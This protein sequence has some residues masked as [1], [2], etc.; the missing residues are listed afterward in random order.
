[1]TNQADYVELGLVCANVCLTL[2]R[3]LEEK[4]MDELSN[5]V[6][7]AIIQLT[8]CVTPITHISSTSLTS[9]ST[10]PQGCGGDPAEGNQAGK[11]KSNFPNRPCEERQGQDCGLEVGLHPDPSSLQCMFHCS[12]MT[13]ANRACLDQTFNKYT[14]CCFRH[15]RH[16]VLDLSHRSERLGGR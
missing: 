6:C 12:R 2:S 3:G 13:V 8:A 9:F 16:G 7:E 15:S 11:T 14:R 5:S 4:R 1:M 10:W